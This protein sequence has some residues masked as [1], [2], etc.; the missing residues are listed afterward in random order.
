M[1]ID[2]E[3]VV[4]GVSIVEVCEGGEWWLGRGGL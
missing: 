1:S 4:L 2:H 3:N